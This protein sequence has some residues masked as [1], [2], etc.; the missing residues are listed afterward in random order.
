MTQRCRIGLINGD[1]IGPEV[2]P[3]AA[4]IVDVA[5]TRTGCSVEWIPLEIG[6]AA[7]ESVGEA[8]P[9]Q[10]LSALDDLDM[11]I[12]GPHDSAGYPPEHRTGLT[13][14]A[15]IRKRFDLYANIRPAVA[16]PGVPALSPQ[17]DLII[18]RENSEGLYADRNMVRGTGEFMPTPDVALAVGVI[19]RAA[20]ER[21]ALSAFELAMTRRKQVT[22]VHKANVLTMTTG[23]FRD[24]CREIGQRYP[25]V[26]ITEQHVDAM[27]AHLV[28]RGHEFD[29]VVT[30][31]LFGDILSDLAAELAGSL[32]SA[33]SVNS[34]ADKVMAQAA[35]GAAPDI[36]G[37]NIANPVG[38]IGSAAM[39]LDWQAARTGDRDLAV[40]AT[41]IRDAVGSTLSK[42]IATRDLDGLATTTEFADAVVAAL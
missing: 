22:I 28:R 39:M 33:A 13:P 1:G 7:I 41:L 42:G 30:E 37:Q 15:V 23:L 24:V 31:S 16:Y 6:R 17:M 4:R 18:V 40:A 29:V 34:S 36:A 5:L 10:T 26:Q 2:V 8:I 20:T 12:L 9:E 38:I 25:Q 11:W 35:H 19:T 3:A 14:G 21:I 32:G 27:A